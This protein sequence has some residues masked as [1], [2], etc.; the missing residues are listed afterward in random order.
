MLENGAQSN[1]S[2]KSGGNG[3]IS[4]KTFRSEHIWSH[5]N[6]ASMTSIIILLIC[7]LGGNYIKLRYTIGEKNSANSAVTLVIISLQHVVLLLKIVENR[8]NREAFI[9]M[10]LF[11]TLVTFYNQINQTF[12]S[13]FSSFTC[14]YIFTLTA[15]LCCCHAE[16]AVWPMSNTAFSVCSQL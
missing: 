7:I 8:L 12:A 9:Q 5:C 15:L 11:Y 6:P 14:L 13:K 10:L 3:A 2:P 1:N 16:Q 4:E